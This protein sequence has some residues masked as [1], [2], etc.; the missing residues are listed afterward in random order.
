MSWLS[1]LFPEPGP[2]P[3]KI[4]VGPCDVAVPRVLLSREEHAAVAEHSDPEAS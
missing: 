3:E 1:W 4:R 2:D